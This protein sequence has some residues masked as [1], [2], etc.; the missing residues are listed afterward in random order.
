MKYKYSKV[1]DISLPHF[2][3]M[4]IAALL[5]WLAPALRAAELPDTHVLLINSYHPGYAWSDDIER[6]LHRGLHEALEGSGKRLELSVEY[7]DSKRFPFNRQLPL[8]RNLLASKYADYRPNLIV[9]S[10]NAAYDFILQER[11]RLFPGIPVVFCGY[12]NYRPE[13]RDGLKLIT[14]VNEEANFK[15]T[16]DMALKIHP[17]TRSLAFILSTNDSTNQRIGEAVNQQLLPQLRQRYQVKVFN[18][19][20]LSELDSGLAKLPPNSLLFLAGQ[21]REQANGRMLTPLDNGR[22]VTKISPW[23]I[24]SF[25][26]FYIG[27]GIVGGHMV[28]GFDQGLAAARQAQQILAGTPADD[29]PIL[30][31]SPSTPLFSYPDLQRYGIATG[32]LP[33]D[34]RIV[35]EP[36]TLW[37]D[38]KGTIVA[39]LSLIVLETLLIFWLLRSMR[40]RR[41]A[42]TQ[43]ADERAR[44]E[45]TVTTRT[46]KLQRS[47]QRMRA[48]LDT[49]RVCIFVVDRNG[50]IT[51]ANRYMSELFERPLEQ[52]LGS[53]Y[54]SLIAPE[55]RDIGREKML[56]L[57]RSQISSVD[58]DRLYWRGDGRQFWGHLNGIR[59]NEEGSDDSYLIGVIADI[60]E[61]K[62]AQQELE[63][64][65]Q[66]LEAQVGERTEALLQAKEA[67]EAASRAK[68]AFLAN[69]SHELRTPMN[70][71]LGMLSLARRR[72]ND[73]T[74][75]DQLDKASSAAKH[76][77]AVLNDILDISKIEAERLQLEQHPLQLGSVLESLTHL[78]MGLARDKGLVFAVDLPPELVRLPLLGDPLRLG[79]ILINLTGNAI[80]FTQ[81]GSVTLLVSLLRTNPGKIDLRF[82]VRDTGIGIPTAVTS[83]LFSSFE[84]GDNSTT[85]KFGGT[86]LGLAICKR[87]VGLMGGEIGVDSQEGV[88]SCFWFTLSLEK[89]AN[90]ADAPPE[91]AFIHIEANLRRLHAGKR[92]LLAE[93][94]P[95]NA[96]IATTLLHDAGLEVELAGDGAAAV[97][98]ARQRRYD[99]ILM[100]IQMP[101]MNGLD[102][103]RAI[104]SDSQNRC[105]PILAMTANVFAEDRHQ[106]L[107]AGMNAHVA[108]PVLP[109]QLFHAVMTWLPE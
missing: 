1:N 50:R 16:V 88:G 15:A 93:D 52:L 75:C 78:Q 13:F 97:A 85:R 21:I 53:E 58:L 86:G 71:V 36:Q 43:L 102:A 83:R 12:N 76:L 77:L 17:Q 19:P 46:A 49:A 66:H 5:L 28:N 31:Q 23:P 45:Q 82:E 107:A 94:D 33:P 51:H 108:K 57:M 100:D 99:L 24:Y 101:V 103:A 72:M 79:Q 55:E 2:I 20:T 9:V 65:Q 26:D 3:H 8:L 7:L 41:L 92:L 98:A 62:R 89:D 27:T 59:L 69:M 48:L 47:E 6:G 106:C 54:V 67:A 91:Q 61:R 56:Q 90:P 64:Y 34:S 74:G 44:L 84:Q 22:M 96:E 30:M 104:R 11:D 87:L 105:T 42:L 35:G 37:H 68:S 10:D 32:N 70:G 29:I 63:R 39:V 38:H 40:E 81:Q 109:E 4:L 25:W 14:G 60:D 95:L 80:K 18:N 73:P